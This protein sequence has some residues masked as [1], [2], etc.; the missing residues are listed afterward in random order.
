MKM[1]KK[2]VIGIGIAIIFIVIA[3][4]SLNQGKSEYTDFRDA[5]TTKK[6][7]QVA[8]E[9]VKA[10]PYKFDTK[11]QSFSFYMRDT[12]NFQS[13]V[14]YQGAMPSNFE[15]APRIV[16][17]GKFEDSV[18]RASSILTKCPSKYNTNN[19]IR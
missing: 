3:L 7:V 19:S 9:W 17:K 16:V 2:Y 6:S 8:G 11:T 14:V 12:T 15:L 13:F 18:F 1:N 10:L 4:T 5:K